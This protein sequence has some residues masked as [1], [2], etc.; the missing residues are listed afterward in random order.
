MSERQIGR[1]THDQFVVTAAPG[2]NSAH[3]TGHHG[4]QTRN[5]RHGAQAVEACCA[6]VLGRLTGT[7]G[8]RHS[9][10]GAQVTI[11][12]R[13]FTMDM[14]SLRRK[15]TP[16]DQPRKGAQLGSGTETQEMTEEQ[17]LARNPPHA[18]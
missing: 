14:A 16:M 2:H 8:F 9:E 5:A 15:P 6:S 17:C 12:Q 7:T 11:F 1:A 10:H 3:A 4:A 18:T 13:H